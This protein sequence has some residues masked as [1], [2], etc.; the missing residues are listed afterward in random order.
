MGFEV[1]VSEGVFV[2]M[3]RFIVVNIHP[4]NEIIFESDVV[5]R[6]VLIGYLFG[7]QLQ[8]A[9]Q[10]GMPQLSGLAQQK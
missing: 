1:G 2:D 8:T 4:P 10:R 9:Q 7:Q 3:L 6:Y 5:K